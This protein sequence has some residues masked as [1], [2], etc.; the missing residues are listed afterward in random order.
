MDVPE[1]DPGSVPRVTALFCC[2]VARQP[3]G[4]RPVGG[5]SQASLVVERQLPQARLVF[6]SCF[7]FRKNVAGTALPLMNSP[8]SVKRTNPTPT[9]ARVSSDESIIAIIEDDL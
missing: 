6:A 1:R 5:C 3:L 2:P 4:R 8:S 7:C 9:L